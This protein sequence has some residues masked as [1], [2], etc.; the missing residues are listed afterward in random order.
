M[1]WQKGAQDAGAVSDDSVSGD[2]Q[3]AFRSGSA[4][5]AVPVRDVGA[6]GLTRI[7]SAGVCAN[8]RDICSG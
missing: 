4:R 1:S 6:A 2:Y 5:A 3:R 7:C 8:Q